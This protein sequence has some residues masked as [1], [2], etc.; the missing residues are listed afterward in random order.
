MY[1]SSPRLLTFALAVLLLP[2]AFPRPLIAQSDRPAA[3]GLLVVAHGADSAWN[4]RVDAVA[5]EVSWPG[6]VETVFLMG[7]AAESRTWDR[8]LARLV[9]HG[10]TRAVA[11][12]LMVSSFGAH[13][14]QIQFYAGEIPELPPELASMGHMHQHTG[15]NPIPVSVTGALDGAPELGIVLRDRFLALS[16]REQLAPL[17]FVAHGPVNEVDVPKWLAGLNHAL[18]PLAEAHTDAPIR[19]GLLRDDADPPI[20]AQ[21]IATLRDTITALAGR[22]GDSVT[23]MTV[24]VSSGQID[25]VKVPN[26]LK[27][28]PMRYVG[29]VLA[30]HPAL[31]QWI[32]RMA[33]AERDRVTAAR[34]SS[35]I[36]RQRL[37]DQE[38]GHADHQ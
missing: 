13:A 29:S 11:V 5:A 4:A 9:E 8:A 10:A 14:R 27:G 15:G 26:D 28:L 35:Q 22:A 36:D 6:P 32:V 24:L 33:S 2:G 34:H 12:P 25:R 1:L 18:R 21:A 19:I 23:V 20:R 37:P 31:A 7:S 30:P 38:R 17:V 3:V 16:E